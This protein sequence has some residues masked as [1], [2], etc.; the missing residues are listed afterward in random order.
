MNGG[1]LFTY[2]IVYFDLAHI[3]QVRD[4]QDR[5]FFSTFKFNSFPYLDQIGSIL[6]LVR[7][8]HVNSVIIVLHL[9]GF[10]T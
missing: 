2:T 1:Q 6:E 5:K 7:D 3:S 9:Q 10:N 8:G 4:R